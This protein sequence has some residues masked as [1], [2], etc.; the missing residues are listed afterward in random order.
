MQVLGFSYQAVTAVTPADFE[1]KSALFRVVFVLVLLA[2]TVLSMYSMLM[3]AAVGTSTT[4][5]AFKL[6]PFGAEISIQTDFLL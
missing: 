1:G 5:V 2:T 6:C 4:A 3:C